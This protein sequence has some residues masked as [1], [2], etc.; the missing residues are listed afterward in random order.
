MKRW[1]RWLGM[2]LAVAGTVFFVGYALSSLRLD[3]L[4]PHLSARAGAAAIFAILLYSL[5]VPISAVAWR[6]LLASLGCRLPFAR[7]NAILLTTQA[8]KYLPGNVGQHLGRIGLALAQGIPAPVLLVSIVYE[9]LLVMLAGV[10][11]GIICGAL[12]A[13]GLAWLLQGRGAALAAA[14]ALAV[15]GLIAIPLLGKALHWL[16]VRASRSRGLEAEPLRLPGWS[17]P[18]SLLAVYAFAYL[19]IGAAISMLA[20]GLFPVAALDFMLLTAV[21]AIAWVA[22]FM[23]PGAPAGIGVREALLLLMLGGSMTAADA[24]LLILSLRVVTTLGD[25]LCFV[26]GL[27]QMAWL[28]RTATPIS[29]H[30]P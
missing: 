12:S 15:A 29:N 5:T 18:A 19:V 28:R 17:V 25:M 8:G 2:A 22:G 30:S 26:A 21:F 20:A 23:T 16:I 1:L 9:M 27:V 10:L 11:V 3:D 14:I 6:R 7:L 24:S 4:R 13:P